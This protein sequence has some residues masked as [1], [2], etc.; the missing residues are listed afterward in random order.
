M[1]FKKLLRRMSLEQLQ[2]L[3]RMKKNQ[4]KVEKLERQRNRH[5]KAAAK[6]QKRIDGLSDG[7]MRG[8]GRPPGRRRLS[9]EARRR[10]AD[11]QKRRWAKWKKAKESAKA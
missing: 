7:T 3:I 8:P 2:K 1:A 6:V 4:G 9:A 10:I 5:L 11:A